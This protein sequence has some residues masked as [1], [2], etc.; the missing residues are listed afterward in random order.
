V[1]NVTDTIFAHVLKLQPQILNP[2]S[3]KV[4][5]YD[6]F[7][8]A[9]A[10][11]YS[12]VTTTGDGNCF[13]YAIS[14]ALTNSEKFA[15]IFRYLTA[16]TLLKEWRFIFGQANE[17]ITADNFRV[18]TI[19]EAGNVNDTGLM[20][21]IEIALTNGRW[22]TGTH[23]LAMSLALHLPIYVFAPFIVNNANVYPH[24]TELVELQNL[25][26]DRKSCTGLHRYYLGY[27][28]DENKLPINIFYS[29]QNHFSA[30]L[31][32]K[33]NAFILKPKNT[34][35]LTKP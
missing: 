13:F 1:Q 2:S 20:D 15:G 30:I 19:D 8:P 26:N 18:P 31:P 34:I 5:Q 23:I 7:H 11:Q 4:V 21:H 24:V 27:K 3:N 17:E 28:C 9:F 33:A 25:M 35:C 6:G 12:I 32:K 22:A 29:D 14:L 16:V 10:A